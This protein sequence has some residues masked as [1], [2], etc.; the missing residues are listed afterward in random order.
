M[1][2]PQNMGEKKPDPIDTHQ[3]HIDVIQD[4]NAYEVNPSHN[5]LSN[6]NIPRLP[7][8]VQ[9]KEKIENRG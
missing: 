7:N 6:A 2:Q 1:N 4:T 9:Q 3:L 8:C 5:T